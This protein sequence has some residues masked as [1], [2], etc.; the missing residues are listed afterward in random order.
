LE[1]GG[2]FFFTGKLPMM[3]TIALQSCTYK[4]NKEYQREW[5]GGKEEEVGVSM[6]KIH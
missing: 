2:I 1:E 4:P 5:E 3:Q 6:I